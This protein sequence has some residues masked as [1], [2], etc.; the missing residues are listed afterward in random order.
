[1]SSIDSGSRAGWKTGNFS[2]H[3][4][5][6]A[7]VCIRVKLT[8]V[9]YSLVKKYV[10]FYGILVMI[11][12]PESVSLGCTGPKYTGSP[13]NLLHSGLTETVV[14]D[15]LKDPLFFSPL[16]DYLFSMSSSCF[17][18]SFILSFSLFVG[19]RENS[20]SRNFWKKDEREG[21]FLSFHI[22]KYLNITSY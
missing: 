4:Q 18:F 17:L 13:P 1:M 20:D 15:S 7:Q 14:F 22:W 10:R 3:R 8:R 19:W 5:D 9:F 16:L 12:L 6:K 21:H 2:A 11:V